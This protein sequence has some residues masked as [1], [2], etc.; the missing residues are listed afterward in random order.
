L[1]L[2]NNGMVRRLADSLA[3]RIVREVGHDPHA[4]IESLYWLAVS[5][6]PT[7]EEA[8]ASL[9]TLAKLKQIATAD[10]QTNK[11]TDIQ[12]ESH[13]LAELCHTVFNSAAFIYID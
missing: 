13:A 9:E 5:R 11:V 10:G 4:Q 12:V 1:Y 8:K 3:D 6:A 2:M 7:A